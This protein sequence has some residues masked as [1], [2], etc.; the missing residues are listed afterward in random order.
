[1][2]QAEG[3]KQEHDLM[4]DGKIWGFMENGQFIPLRKAVMIRGGYGP[5]PFTL[6]LPDG[7][8]REIVSIPDGSEK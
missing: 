4:N 3:D 2:E 1:M 5:P 7:R 8:D 6:R